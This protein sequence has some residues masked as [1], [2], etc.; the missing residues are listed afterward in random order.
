MEHSREG[1]LILVRLDPGEELL[2]GML[3]AMEQRGAKSALIVSGIGALDSVEVGYFDPGSKSYQ[4]ASLEGSHE[5]VSTSGSVGWDPDQG[6]QPHVHV[7][8]AGRDH[9]MRGGHLFAARVS[10]TA[11]LALRVLRE[12]VVRRHHNPETGLAQMRM[13]GSR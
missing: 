2:G 9:T 11:E 12:G 6:F 13:G 1:G 7:A 3:Q 5:L 10:V 4:R 8:L